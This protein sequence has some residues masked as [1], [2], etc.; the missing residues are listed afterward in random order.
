MATIISLSFAG[1]IFFLIFANLLFIIHPHELMEDGD[2]TLISQLINVPIE[3]RQYLPKTTFYNKTANVYEILNEAFVPHHN[4]S[5]R[6][7]IKLYAPVEGKERELLISEYTCEPGNGDYM[8]VLMHSE[9]ID[10]VRKQVNDVYEP[11]LITGDCCATQ[12]PEYETFDISTPDSS[13]DTVDYDDRLAQTVPPLQTHEGPKLERKRRVVSTAFDSVGDKFF[14]D[15]FG[16]RYRAI[17]NGLVKILTTTTLSM[18]ERLVEKLRD[19]YI[20]DKRNM[21]KFLEEEGAITRSYFNEIGYDIIKSID[22]NLSKQYWKNSMEKSND[23]SMTQN[24]SFMTY[25]SSRVNQMS[26]IFVNMSLQNRLLVNLLTLDI[27]NAETHRTWMFRFL[28]RVY[29]NVNGTIS[30]QFGQFKSKITREQWCDLFQL[31]IALSTENEKHQK[32]VGKEL[33]D[34]ITPLMS[35]IVTKKQ[36]Y[37]VDDCINLRTCNYVYRCFSNNIHLFEDTDEYSIVTALFSKFT[38]LHHRLVVDKLLKTRLNQA[39]YELQVTTQNLNGRRV[40]YEMYNYAI[41]HNN[42]EDVTMSS[43]QI[44]K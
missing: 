40:F 33:M 30:L 3:C 39:I 23:S 19:R 44:R 28:S 41:Y 36:N 15:E 12:T 27:I 31:L 34:V 5:V 6:T 24:E 16:N 25:I 37:N 10:H 1:S 20:R 7:N 21:R 32:Q 35:M 18:G 8:L 29:F 2:T 14:V 9:I 38:N 13:T 42:V 26:D 17:V 22:N 11:K 43:F 4:F